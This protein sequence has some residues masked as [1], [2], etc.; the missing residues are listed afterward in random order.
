[1]YSLFEVS[2]KR[3]NK[4]LV[5]RNDKSRE[6]LYYMLPGRV[7]ASTSSPFLYQV[8]HPCKQKEESVQNTV[9]SSKRQRDQNKNWNLFHPHPT[10]FLL[11]PLF[12]LSLVFLLFIICL[13]CIKITCWF[14][15]EFRNWVLLV[16][17]SE[18]GCTGTGICHAYNSSVAYNGLL[19]AS[20]RAMPT[21]VMRAVPFGKLRKN[22]FL[23]SM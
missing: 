19:A 10:H 7:T 3:I 2:S 15:I 11:T 9:M 5:K 13:L 22:L 4:K 14:D 16:T 23:N 17:I 8:Y 21:R 6:I 18:I 1:M 12:F 20:P